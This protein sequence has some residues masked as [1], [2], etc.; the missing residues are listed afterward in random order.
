MPD[1]AVLACCIHRLENQQQRPAILGIKHVLLL[2]EPLGTALKEFGRLAL[3][4][5]QSAGVAG[6][7]VLQL[8]TL[9]FCDAEGLNVLLDL[10]EDLFSR[11][12]PPI[13]QSKTACF[14][15]PNSV[16]QELC[17]VVR[18]RFPA[19]VKY[20]REGKFML[21]SVWL[22]ITTALRFNHDRSAIGVGEI[23]YIAFSLDSVH[24]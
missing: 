9:A 20:A 21:V 6:I 8:K 5:L 14:T 18:E 23:S 1:R 15:S 7:K 24:S 10:V 12:R 22:R 16:N 13:R 4:H 3:A 17:Q 2:C 11:H 19:L